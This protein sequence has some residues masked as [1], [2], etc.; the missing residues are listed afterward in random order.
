MGNLAGGS[1]VPPG[2][3]NSRRQCDFCL[4]FSA[5]YQLCVKPCALALPR[6]KSR[7]S[8]GS[9]N[10]LVLPTSAK[11]KFCGRWRNAV[12]ALDKIPG[13]AGKEKQVANDLPESK[14]SPAFSK[15]VESKGE[16]F[17][18]SAHGAKFFSLQKRRRGGETVRRTVFGVGNPRRGFPGA[19]GHTEFA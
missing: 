6:G 14:I 2:T 15:A 4:D 9:E 8:L 13:R 17:G 19:A 16:T 5:R 3:P 1:P 10:S 7:L 18:R 12:S 11:I